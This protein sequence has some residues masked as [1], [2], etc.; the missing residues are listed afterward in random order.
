MSAEKVP[1]VKF[2]PDLIQFYDVCYFLQAVNTDNR[3]KSIIDYIV[4]MS[5]YFIV[6]IMF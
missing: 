1:P 2:T 3:I 4:N 6:F 5:L